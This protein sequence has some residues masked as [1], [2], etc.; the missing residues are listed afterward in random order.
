VVSFTAQKYYCVHTIHY[1]KQCLKTVCG[2]DISG[3]YAALYERRKC[4]PD[5]RRG[6]G[7]PGGGFPGSR[8]PERER[9][10]PRFFFFPIYGQP[11]NRCDHTDRYG[12]CCDVFGRCYYDYYGGE[13]TSESGYGAGGWDTAQDY[14][15]G[16]GS[17]N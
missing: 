4:M 16:I 1:R 3:L 14:G 7:R 5:G 15:D 6:G 13:D 17:D 12:R 10:F 8:F 2:L 9:R 11:Y